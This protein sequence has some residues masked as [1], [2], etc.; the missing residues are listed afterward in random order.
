MRANW[1]IEKTADGASYY[2]QV[3]DPGVPGSVRVDDITDKQGRR[4]GD[5]LLEIE[6]R[7]RFQALEAVRDALGIEQR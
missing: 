7:A 2:L 6:R 5:A 4:L 1:R 3:G